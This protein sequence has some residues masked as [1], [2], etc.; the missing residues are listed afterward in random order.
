M[1]LCQPPCPDNID[2]TS[3]FLCCAWHRI[4]HTQQKAATMFAIRYSWS[5]M[6]WIKHRPTHVIMK[7][8]LQQADGM[9]IHHACVSYASLFSSNAI[10]LLPDAHSDYVCGLTCVNSFM[11][12]VACPVLLCVHVH[13]SYIASIKVQCCYMK[14][15]HPT[16]LCRQKSSDIL[17]NFDTF[18]L[19]TPRYTPSFSAACDT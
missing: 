19:T 6:Q 1:T 12:T 3:S 9:Q 15:L 5:V 13:C 7:K 2:W 16:Q 4:Q 14:L 18:S 8:L 10:S 11:V 17:S